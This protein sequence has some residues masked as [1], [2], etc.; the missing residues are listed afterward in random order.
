[1]CSSENKDSKITYK[2]VYDVRWR[3]RD[4]E[5]TTF[6]QRAILFG[7]F[8]VLAYTGY[9][10]LLSMVME[11][12]EPISVV[13]WNF[14]NLVAVGISCFGIITSL[15]WILLAKGSKAW[16]NR[17]ESAISA[18][19]KQELLKAFESTDV[20]NVAGF[21]LTAANNK[22]YEKNFGK[23]DD[24]ILSAK[25]GAYS[26][27]R[28]IACL[29]QVSFIGWGLIAI[30]HLVALMCGREKFIKWFVENSSAAWIAFLMIA[31][32]LLFIRPW[33]CKQTESDSLKW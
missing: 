23:N 7:S 19:E 13:R 8:M 11:M 26:V 30:A 25:A 6:W 15:L 18:F 21:Q 1:M 33:I 20:Q 3:C 28:V 12:K 2:D 9:G 17:N 29:G 4:L 31:V 32:T 24:G 5:L 27:S 10:V 16:I 14:V 22:Y